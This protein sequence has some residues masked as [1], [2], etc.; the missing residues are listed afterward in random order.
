MRL[1]I[2]G[3]MTGLPEFNYPAFYKAE[4]QLGAAG[5]EIENPARNELKDRPL[6]E[7]MWLSFMRMSLVQISTVDGMALL[8]G[9]ASS[10][11]AT[12][13]A[14]IGR[15]LKLPVLYLDDWL[16]TRLPLGHAFVGIGKF[17]SVSA[18]DSDRCG[19]Q[20]SRYPCGRPAAVHEPRGRALTP[21]EA[22]ERAAG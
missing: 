17:S 5:Y 20:L 10:S 3:P 22:S 19:V 7:P 14:H 11:G 18:G 21:A 2:A 6:G 8:D 9:W 16:G 15:G 13:E 12:L 4:E 1:Y